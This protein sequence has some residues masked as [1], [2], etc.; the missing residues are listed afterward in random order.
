MLGV[1]LAFIRS[2]VN[3]MKIEFEF[4]CGCGLG[5]FRLAAD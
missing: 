4:G 3:E 2:F 5:S 1:D